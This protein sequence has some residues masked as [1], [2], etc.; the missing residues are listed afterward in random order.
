MKI[1]K[2]KNRL[3]DKIKKEMQQNNL[4]LKNNKQKM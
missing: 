3:K 1:K 4:L 2:M